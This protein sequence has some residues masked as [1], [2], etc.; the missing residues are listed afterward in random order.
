MKIKEGVNLHG[1]QLPMR[2][3]LRIASQ[4]WG[5]MNYPFVV[6]SAR[7]GIHSPGSLHYYGLAIDF[8]TWRNG[9]GK[10]MTDE[11]RDVL[12]GLLRLNLG[13]ISDHYQVIAEKTHIHVEYDDGR[14]GYGWSE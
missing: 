9:M 3:V 7:D 14:Y 4:L 5:E 11:E 2:A 1:L 12:V 10:Q 6:T 13:E 8:R